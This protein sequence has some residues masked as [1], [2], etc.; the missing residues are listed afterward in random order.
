MS[1]DVSLFVRSWINCLFKKGGETVPRP[2]GLKLNGNKTNY[3]L[4]LNTLRWEWGLL[5]RNTS[6]YYVTI[7]VHKG[8]CTQLNQLLWRLQSMNYYTSAR[9]SGHHQNLFPTAQNTSKTRL[10]NAL[11][12]GSAPHIISSPCIARGVMELWND[13]EESSYASPELCYQNYN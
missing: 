3:L 6:S 12:K 4:Q 10:C 7:T 8:G 11:K 5:A 2:Y 13:V 9:L 1:K